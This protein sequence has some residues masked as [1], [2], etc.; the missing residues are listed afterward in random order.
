MN[1]KVF[2][3]QYATDTLTMSRDAADDVLPTSTNI[4]FDV[5]APPHRPVRTAACTDA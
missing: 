1:L 2:Y 5:P 4:I 3:S